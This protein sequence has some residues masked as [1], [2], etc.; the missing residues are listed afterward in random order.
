MA[1][2]PKFKFANLDEASLDRVKEL[3]SQ[4]DDVYI[5]ALEPRV[6][7]ADLSSDQVEQIRALEQELGVVLL[8]Y[9][10]PSNA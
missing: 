8:A 10:N 9:N 3:E 4:M 1:D 6:E 5:L 2:K 7:L